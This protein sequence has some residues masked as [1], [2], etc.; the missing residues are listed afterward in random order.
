MIEISPLK[1]IDQ[2]KESVIILYRRVFA[3]VSVLDTQ[4]TE[5]ELNLVDK[6]C[7][8]TCAGRAGTDLYY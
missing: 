2:S 6:Y 4:D 7:E 1:V 5:K 8:S 3:F